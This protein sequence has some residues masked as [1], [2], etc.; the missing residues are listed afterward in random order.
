M[1]T[2]SRDRSGRTPLSYAAGIPQ[3]EIAA[4][5][6]YKSANPD[7]KDKLGRTPLSYAAGAGQEKTAA[8]LLNH[9]AEPDSK[10]NIGRTPLSYA[11][12]SGSQAVATLLLATQRVNPQ[13]KDNKGRTPLWYTES[14][15]VH[16]NLINRR[17]MY[18]VPAQAT[19]NR[20]ISHLLAS[21]ENLQ[22]RIYRHIRVSFRLQSLR[23]LFGYT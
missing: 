3:A 6:L 23:A 10:D 2:D 8:L 4:R 15:Q 11:F 17:E 12:A 19:F 18:T 9:S 13:S 21:D 14:T 16:D 20:L 7:S 22:R 5:L 1:E